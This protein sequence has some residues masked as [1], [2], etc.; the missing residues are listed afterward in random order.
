MDCGGRGGEG[1][2]NEISQG[3]VEKGFQGGQGGN[4]VCLDARGNWVQTQVVTER[5][6]WRL[7]G[8]GNPEVFFPCY[9]MQGSAN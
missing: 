9:F 3:D 6:S 5:L 2:R 1:G 7:N 8:L 4:F